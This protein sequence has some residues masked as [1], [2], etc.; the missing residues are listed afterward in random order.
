MAE[1]KVKAEKKIVATAGAFDILR[2][3]IITEKAA[4]LS[5]KNGVAF[6]VAANATKED[7]ARAVEAVYNVKP[8]KINIVVAKGK[9]KSFR[10]RNSGTQRTVKKAYVT[11]PA[12]AK[13]D[14]AVSVD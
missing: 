5:E 7:V 13:L 6:E 1:K 12:D 10:G 4:K 9:V 2:R 8:T 11:L 3:P 14:L